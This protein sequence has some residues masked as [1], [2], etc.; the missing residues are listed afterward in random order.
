MFQS[1]VQVQ[2]VPCFEEITLNAHAQDLLIAMQVSHGLVYKLADP[3][4]QLISRYFREP[5]S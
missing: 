5:H 2:I 3:V 4:I 1:T